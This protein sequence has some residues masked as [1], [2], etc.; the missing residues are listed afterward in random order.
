MKQNAIS[1]DMV[2]DPTKVKPKFIGSFTKRQVVCYGLAAAIGI[3]FYLL[4]KDTIG[5]YE[6][7]SYVSC[8]ATGPFEKGKG[9]SGTNYYW[10]KYYSY[11]IKTAKLVGLRLILALFNN[12]YVYIRCYEQVKHLIIFLVRI[13]KFRFTKKDLQ[14]SKF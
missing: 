13:Y 12:A 6:S 5:K 7:G 10:G 14:K 11:Q 8:R 2:K 1:V 4:V 9:L 3:P